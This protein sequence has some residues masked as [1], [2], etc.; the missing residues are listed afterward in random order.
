VLAVGM[1]GSAALLLR[2]DDRG[3][4][5]A[6]SGLAPGKVLGSPRS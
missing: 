3:G 2:V 6:P 5:R 1:A 4:A